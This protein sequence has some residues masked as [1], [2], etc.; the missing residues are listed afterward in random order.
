MRSLL[1]LS[2]LILAS[3]FASCYYG[4]L[5][6]RNPSEPSG[7]SGPATTN[8]RAAPESKG[9]TF[10][11][12]DDYPDETNGWQ[13]LGVVLMLFSLFMVT[14][15]TLVWVTDK[16]QGGGNESSEILKLR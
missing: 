4:S 10:Y 13:I 5:Y 14:V 1:L 8:T 16:F 11:I 12:S 15:A 3:G 7:S 6:T 2:L 9:D